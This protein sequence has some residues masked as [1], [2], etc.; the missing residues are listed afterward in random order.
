[1]KVTSQYITSINVMKMEH[2]QQISDLTDKLKA[3]ELKAKPST[4]DNNTPTILKLD[5]GSQQQKT[6]EIGS[7]DKD[8]NM[9]GT[10]MD[11][12][13]DDKDPIMNSIKRKRR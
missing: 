10:G 1:M 11:S 6:I 2:E 3:A 9:S 4:S 5:D 8:E 13:N 12:S 7:N